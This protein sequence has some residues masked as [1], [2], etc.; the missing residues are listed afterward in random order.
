MVTK[1]H[2]PPSKGL[3]WILVSPST[4]LP[5]VCSIC[6][7]GLA[8]RSALWVWAYGFRVFGLGRGGSSDTKVSGMFLFVFFFFWGGVC[9]STQTPKRLVYT[10][11]TKSYFYSWRHK[12]DNRG[13]HK[14]QTP[15]NLKPYT[16]SEDDTRRYSPMA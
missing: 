7:T 9:S 10:F 11:P 13:L 15:A 4:Q 8:N 6:S 2:E 14:P 1:S 16:S 5:L 3:L 12:Y